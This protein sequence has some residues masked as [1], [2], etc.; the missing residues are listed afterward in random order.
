MALTHVGVVDVQAGRLWTDQTVVV[1]GNRI[2]AVGN[3]STLALPT[4]ARVVDATGQ[5]LIPGLWDM[6]T[7]VV[8]PDM[9]GGPDVSFPLLIANGVTG[10]RDMGSSDLDSIIK[11]RSEVRAATRLGPRMLVAGKV[12][13]GSPPVFPPDQ[14]VVR[15]P[16]EARRA[17][18]SLAGRGVDFI[19]PYE[20]LQRD[21][22]L[23]IVD[24]AAR[25][26][27]PVAAH[28]PLVMDV[29]EASDLGIRSFEHLRNLELACSRR[30]D[31]LRTARTAELAKEA[32]RRDTS[33]LAFDWSLGYGSGA[34]VRARIHAAQRQLARETLDL[35]RCMALLRRLARNGTWQDVTLI[36]NEITALRIDTMPVIRAALRYV[37]A[38]NRELWARDAP[39][40]PPGGDSAIQTHGGDKGR[41]N[42][43]AQGA[44]YLR[45]VRMMRDQGV[46]ILAGTDISN[47]YIVPGFALHDELGL[48]VR[49]GLSPLEALRAATLNPA[50][51]LA[52]TDSLGTVAIG[53]RADL[54]LLDANPLVDIAN[55]RRI[56]A[57]FVNGRYLDRGALDAL[58]DQAERAA[59]RQ[60][61]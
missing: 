56:R 12:L 6:H 23:A 41:Q 30:A 29:G 24:A 40:A 25:H 54:V 17:V 31:S 15:N 45:L 22:F 3:A 57:V 34:L 59:G 36:V 37:P 58:L 18:D 50:R 52:A 26:H 9:P 16:K 13:D 4:G 55:T 53:R 8:D 60:M 51:Y 21:V 39:R 44:W 43:E 38:R 28:V 7:H 48:L 47:P 32:T 10:I 35:P 27:L 33:A 42:I 14:L 46:G 1:A 61:N 49:A 5:Y 20:M 2:A 11:L 19:K